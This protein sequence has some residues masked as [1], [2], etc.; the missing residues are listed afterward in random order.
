MYSSVST[1]FPG[2]IP[3]AISDDMTLHY[4]YD[5]AMW[6]REVIA[7]QYNDRELE[8]LKDACPI[9]P[10]KFVK[11]RCYRERQLSRTE[12]RIAELGG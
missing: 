9:D 5:R 11:I 2:D 7:T 8:I 3:A 10:N 1:K 6:L 12:D 4:L